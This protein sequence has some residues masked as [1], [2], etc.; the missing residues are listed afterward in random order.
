VAPEADLPDD[1]RVVLES[2]GA[3]DER[4]RRARPRK[5][6]EDPCRIGDALVVERHF[7]IELDRDPHGVRQHGATNAL[8][9]RQA[10]G[11]RR[12]F[13]ALACRGGRS[14][15]NPRGISRRR[16]PSVRP[17]RRS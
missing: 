14:S 13:L 2:D 6:D 9:G 16:P 1:V 11:E 7:A 5:V 3:I 12:G 4:R 8:D 15:A 17:R 10:P